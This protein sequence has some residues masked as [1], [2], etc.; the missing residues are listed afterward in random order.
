MTALDAIRCGVFYFIFSR[1]AEANTSCLY[2]KC[3]KWINELGATTLLTSRIVL[4]IEYKQQRCANRV[5]AVAVVSSCRHHRT[6]EQK[7]NND[8]MRMALM[9]MDLES[10]R[11]PRERL[12]VMA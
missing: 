5:A 7:E 12:C 3:M 11:R 2:Q 6:T 9:D 4:V 8:G 10:M 1:L